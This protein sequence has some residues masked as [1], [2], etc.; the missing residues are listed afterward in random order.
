M[1]TF[2]QKIKAFGAWIWNGLGRVKFEIGL[3][4]VLLLLCGL[5]PSSWLDP[6]QINPK[7]AFFSVLLAK[8]LYVNFGIL[9]AHISRKILFPY[10]NIN[11]L[12]Q[13]KNWPA[14][15]LMTV[16][17]GVIIWAMARGG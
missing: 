15:V 5:T 13:E 2:L 4:C 11:G 6:D 10:I 1:Q 8:V 16:W 3:L 17:Y 14:V 12:I 7:V 9:Y